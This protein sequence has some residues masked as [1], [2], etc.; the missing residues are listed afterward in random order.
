M[1]NFPKEMSTYMFL[2]QIGLLVFL[3]T[4][5]CTVVYYYAY[6]RG[7]RQGQMDAQAF[8]ARRALH[9]RVQAPHINQGK[10]FGRN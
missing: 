5:L 1:C 8:N 2:G 10:F 4:L 6:Q 7:F 3:L 9:F